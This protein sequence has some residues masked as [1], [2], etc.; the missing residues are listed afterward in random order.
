MRE[1]PEMH[2]RGASR[3]HPSD[4][5]EIQEIRAVSAVK[6]DYFMA[7]AL[8]MASYRD[9]NVAAMAGHENAHAAMIARVSRGKPAGPLPAVSAVLGFSCYC[10]KGLSTRTNV[11]VEQVGHMPASSSTAHPKSALRSA[12]ISA[13]TSVVPSSSF[14]PPNR[15][16]ARSAEGRVSLR[17]PPISTTTATSSPC[18]VMTCG[19][20]LVT[21]RGALPK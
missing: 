15:M 12:S 16:L 17:Y 20:S 11:G 8:Q 2:D 21:V 14:G 1:S 4:L 13:K 10:P 3:R 19:P 18:R 6:S 7:E 9:T 5:A